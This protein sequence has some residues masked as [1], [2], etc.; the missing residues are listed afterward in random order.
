MEG[1]AAFLM[2]RFNFSGQLIVLIRT[3]RLLGR[4]VQSSAKHRERAP[5][6]LHRAIEN[7]LPT[8]TKEA[9]K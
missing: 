2:L 7:A 5:Q 6:W 1:R 3:V 8:S 4:G 9:R